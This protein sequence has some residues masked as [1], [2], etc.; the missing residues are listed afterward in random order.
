MEQELV[1]QETDLDTQVNNFWNEQNISKYQDAIG[2][3]IS[4]IKEIDDDYYEQSGYH[5]VRFI[6]HRLK[7][8]ES[9]KGKCLRKKKKDTYDIEAVINDLA[10]VRVICYDL[11]QIYVIVNFLKSTSELE[12][13]KVKNYIEKAKDNGYQSYHLIVKIN[14]VKVE[15]QIRTILM[16][17]WSSL[18]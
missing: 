9:I 14:G 17:A 15:I 6:E 1:Q 11:E 12:I 10:G 5:L 3:V 13:L 16:D 2:E 4:Y 7:S 8:A 18:E